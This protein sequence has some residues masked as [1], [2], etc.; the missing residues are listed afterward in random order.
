MN[1]QP[2]PELRENCIP[3]TNELR[4]ITAREGIDAATTLLYRTVLES[5]RYG[6]FIRRIEELRRRQDCLTWDNDAILVIVPGAFYRENPRSGADGHL[7][8]A[9]AE[10]IGCETD[11][12]PLASTGGLQQNATIICEWLCDCEERPVILVSL[13]KGGADI[14]MALSQPGAAAAFQHVVGWINLCG[15]LDGTPNAEWLFSGGVFAK[16][17]R[18]YYNA[19]GQNLEFVRD[20]RRGPGHPLDFELQLPAHLRMVTVVGFPLREHLSSFIARHCHR[21]LAALGPND[22]G[23]VLSDVCAQ[24]GLLYPLWGADHYLRP[25]SGVQDLI[26]ALMEYMI[27]ELR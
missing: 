14:K 1:T 27:E 21:K 12:I 9:Q 6:P 22:C 26:V 2:M 23:L 7:V 25:N 10:R 16:L 17:V 15:I 18:T 8:R 24:P 3:S 4:H 13:S 11:L 19:L 5:T 20:L